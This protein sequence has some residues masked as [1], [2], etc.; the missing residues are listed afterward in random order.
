MGSGIDFQ[1]SEPANQQVYHADMYKRTH[2]LLSHTVLTKVDGRLTINGFI[3]I[4]TSLFDHLY[5]TTVAET[6]GWE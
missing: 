2:P 5:W 1:M 4:K 3:R 6:Q